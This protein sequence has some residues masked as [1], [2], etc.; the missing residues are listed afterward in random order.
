MDYQQSR[1]II[2]SLRGLYGEPIASDR[3]QYVS[4]FR[5]RDD[6][7]NNAIEVYD[8]TSIAVLHV[9]YT[10]LRSGSEKGL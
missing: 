4:K 3:D 7:H 10:S 2:E 8:M 6:A 1:S 9:F 5:L